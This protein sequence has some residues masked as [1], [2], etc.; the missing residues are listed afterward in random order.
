[1]QSFLTT[2]SQLNLSKIP[3]SQESNLQLKACM[4]IEVSKKGQK[5]E[6]GDQCGNAL[7]Y[8]SPED[9][10][11]NMSVAEA[12]INGHIWVDI[13]Q[14]LAYYLQDADSS[15]TWREHLVISWCATEPTNYIYRLY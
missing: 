10:E 15:K 4:K 12:K 14:L 11:S 9:M 2:P 7:F 6:L 3:A 13:A 5:H 8:D 1:M